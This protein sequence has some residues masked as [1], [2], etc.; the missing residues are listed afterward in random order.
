V[1]E[2]P[3]INRHGEVAGMKVLVV[4]GAGFIGSHMVKGLALAGDEPIV[5]DNLGSGFTD[6][7][8][9]G[10]LL[11][12]DAGNPSDVAAALEA[13]P[14]DAVMHFASHIQVG[15]SIVDPAKYYANNVAATLALL[16]VIR[17]AG[18]SQF[19]FSST[20]AVYG[21]PCMTPIPEN[22]ALAPINPYGRSKLMVEEVLADFDAAYGLKSVCLRY[23]NA[24]GADPEGELGERHEPETHLIPLVLQAAAGRRSDIAVFGR[25]YPTRDGTCVRDY[26]HVTDLVEA[27]RLALGYLGER[28]ISNT[29]N[30]GTGVGYTVQEVID[31][32]R[33][34]TGYP[35][36]VRDEARRPGDPPELVADPSRALRE[37][38]WR[39]CL[40]DLD[41]M[42]EHAWRWE[43]KH[44]TGQG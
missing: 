17:G 36:T 34:V 11:I 41:T 42:L 14:C 37:L 26:I 25:D 3:P 38:N 28:G 32:A 29:F 6:A 39:P 20:A 19:I 8:R 10:N 9:Y 15:E 23:F 24:A 13:H 16:Q 35:I 43:R 33:R 18:I 31:A 21:N 7:A 40:S 22:H 12:G 4:G 30:L 27:H 2:A 1:A 5:L 44:H